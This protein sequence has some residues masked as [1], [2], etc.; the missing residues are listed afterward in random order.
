MS[1]EYNLDTTD[2]WILPDGL[3]L[4]KKAGMEYTC[5]FWIRL[6]SS[7]NA[8]WSSSGIGQTG[9]DMLAYSAAGGGGWFSNVSR[10]GDISESHINTSAL[11][12]GVGSQ[13]WTMITITY[14]EGD[15]VRVYSG[16]LFDPPAEVTYK[17]PR[18]LGSGDTTVQSGDLGI[19]NR[20]SG[21]AL[22]L[23]C[24]LHSFV[25]YN[26]HFNA[27]EVKSLWYANRPPK[28]H[29]LA[30]FRFDILSES[31][32]RI[33]DRYGRSYAYKQGSPTLVHENP[34]FGWSDAF[35]ETQELMDYFIPFTTAAGGPT[36][37]QLGLQNPIF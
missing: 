14:S 16:N 25:L 28:E 30:Y 10:T 35:P 3:N 7:P 2:A 20:G 12:F 13:S 6:T 26:R 24:V 17:N 33:V 9:I 8:S 18:E 11:F 34:T 29:C 27:E 1:F 22:A 37:L 36:P 15:D 31:A 32:T 19:I 5:S 4:D 23:N 21:N